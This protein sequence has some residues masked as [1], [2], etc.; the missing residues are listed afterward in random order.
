[1]LRQETAQDHEIEPHPYPF[2]VTD[3]FCKKG[4]SIKGEYRQLHREGEASQRQRWVGVS[5]AGEAR[6][7]S[8]LSP[9]LGTDHA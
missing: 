2:A 6:M 8:L 1:M 7:K 4:E 5:A 9:Q 3:I